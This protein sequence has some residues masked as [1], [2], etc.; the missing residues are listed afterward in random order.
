MA[1]TLSSGIQLSCRESIGGIKYAYILDASG[2]AIELTESNGV[3][4]GISVGGTA[5]GDLSTDMYLFDQIKQTANLVETVNASEENG[6][7]FFTSVL[8]LVFNKL[9]STK[10]NQLKV[11]AANSKLLIVVKDNNDKLWLVGNDNGAVVSGGSSESGTA[12]GDR[13][14]MTIEFTGN[15]PSPM[16]EVTVTE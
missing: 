11:L 6:T 9:E 4:S 8:N 15:H 5:L 3:V 1:C 14:G 7:V 10:L 16:F 12:M 13:N 2:Q